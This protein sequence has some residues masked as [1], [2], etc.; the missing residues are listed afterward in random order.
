MAAS[1]VSGEP[2]VE[3]SAKEAQKPSELPESRSPRF[4]TNADPVPQELDA[5][6]EGGGVTAG[7]GRGEKPPL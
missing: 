3:M 4:E 2:I 6:E 7:R 1:E 5:A